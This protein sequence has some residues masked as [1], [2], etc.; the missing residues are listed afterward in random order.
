MNQLHEPTPRRSFLASSCKGTLALGVGLSTVASLLQSFAFKPEEESALWQQ[1]PTV[2]SEAQFRAAVAGP[3]Q[4]SMMSSQL[5]AT[6]ATNEYAKQFATFELAETTAMMSILKDLGTPPPP[7]DAKAK[8]LMAQLQSASGAAF[9]RAYIAAQIQNHQL[10][11][12]LTDG[13]LANPAPSK[14]NLMELHGRHIA[15][16]ASTTIKEHLAITQ[17]IS[18]VLGS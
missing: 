3:A 9:D 1:S 12:T 2:T 11:R 4:M 18:S 6:K 16:L 5:A 14:T 10:L 15:T 8:A 7:P 17:R 13:Y